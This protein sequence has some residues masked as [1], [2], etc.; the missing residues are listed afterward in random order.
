[1]RPLSR[2]CLGYILITRATGSR[3]RSRRGHCLSISDTRHSITDSTTSLRNILSE[4]ALLLLGFLVHSFPQC[5]LCGAHGSL[6]FY[7]FSAINVLFSYTIK[8]AIP[9]CV[10]DLW[11][12]SNHQYGR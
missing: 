7:F 3:I 11:C 2:V 9:Y 8:G 5:Y 12:T 1:M 6:F 4:V 10:F